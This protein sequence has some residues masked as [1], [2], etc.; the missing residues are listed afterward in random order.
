MN[1]SVNIEL[2][3]DSKVTNDDIVNKLKEFISDRSCYFYCVTVK[4][5]G[6]DP[7]TSWDCS[8]L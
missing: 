3:F 8:E 2:K 1:T 5:E 7:K 6:K 4:N